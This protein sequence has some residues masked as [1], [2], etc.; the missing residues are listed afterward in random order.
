MAR[1]HCSAVAATRPRRLAVA[2]IFFDAFTVMPIGFSMRTLTP[3][4]RS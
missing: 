3:A 1:R 4:C 2:A